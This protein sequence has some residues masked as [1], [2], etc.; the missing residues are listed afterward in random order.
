MVELKDI[1]DL[2][3][4]KKHLADGVVRAQTHPN[5]PELYILNYTEVAQYD[6]I[7]DCVTNVCRGLIVRKPTADWENAEVVARGFNKFHNLNTEYVP[8]TMEA[9]LPSDIPLV[10]EKLDGSMGII[11]EYD[12]QIWVA[13]RGS[14]DS[15]QARWATSFI[16]KNH[17]N[18]RL[19]AGAS[20]VV[21]IIY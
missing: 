16:R 18:L 21:E 17:P 19:P 5:Y 14:F 2:S 4:L 20:V 11:F 6:R 15:E 10:T 3:L 13:T 9:N 12:N 7:W 1:L 8:E